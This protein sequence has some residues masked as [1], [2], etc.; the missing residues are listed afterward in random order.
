VRVVIPDYIFSAHKLVGINGN[1]Q[2]AGAILK[3]SAVFVVPV[4]EAVGQE[5]HG[6]GHVVTG[7]AVDDVEFNR[8]DIVDTL[9]E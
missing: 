7:V 6:Q 4:I 5:L 2:Q 9:R 8:S 3:P 1:V